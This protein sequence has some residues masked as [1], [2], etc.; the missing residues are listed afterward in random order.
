MHDKFIELQGQL[1]LGREDEISAIIGF[2][3]SG[4]LLGDTGTKHMTVPLI[5]LGSSGSGK[6]SLMARCILEMKKVH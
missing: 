1:V 2:A 3:K 4:N 5:I 6:S